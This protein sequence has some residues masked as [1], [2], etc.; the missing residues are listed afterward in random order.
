MANIYIYI[1]N[2]FFS[3]YFI[4]V[5]IFIICFFFFFLFYW[6]YEFFF[7]FIQSYKSI[8]HTMNVLLVDCISQL[9]LC[10]QQRDLL[11][12]RCTL[13][14][15]YCFFSFFFFL[16]IIFVIS[17]F[18]FYILMKFTQLLGIDRQ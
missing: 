11:H 6:K 13:C 15:C 8:Y 4:D 1:Q 14:L 9:G 17:L 2:L 5:C 7:F 10:I 18:S 16:C 12:V 3:G